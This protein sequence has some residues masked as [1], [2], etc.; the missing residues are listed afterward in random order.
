MS[1]EHKV[2]SA[3]ELTT[4][5]GDRRR[6]DLVR[7]RQIYIPELIIRLHS[8]LVNSRSRIHEYVYLAQAFGIANVAYIDHV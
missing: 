7:I 6:R 1:P 8:I 5:V 2:L 4:V 3:S